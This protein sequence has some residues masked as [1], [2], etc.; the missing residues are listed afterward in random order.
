MV[1]R[2]R[3][4]PHHG[5]EPYSLIQIITAVCV[6]ILGCILVCILCL[7]VLRGFINHINKT[8]WPIL[9]SLRN[10]FFVCSSFVFLA[11][12]FKASFEKKELSLILFMFVLGGF[13]LFDGLN[14]MRDL[15][16]GPKSYA[17]YCEVSRRT[18]RLGPSYRLLISGFDLETSRSVVDALKS[19]DPAQGDSHETN[20]TWQCNSMVKISYLPY[21]KVAIKVEK[22]G[23]DK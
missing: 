22:V 6:G 2:H 20:G 8:N 7:F 15:W 23:I 3:L 5:L 12:C 1:E 14:G 11:G 18:D 9:I 17:G 21:N 13:L 19:K 16:S 4:G 10:I